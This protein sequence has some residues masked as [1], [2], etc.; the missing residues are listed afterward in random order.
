LDVE[1][2]IVS[3]NKCF[4]TDHR[5]VACL[6]SRNTIGCRGIE[7]LTE[8]KR[9]RETERETEKQRQ[10]ERDSLSAA[11][12]AALPGRTH[13]GRFAGN[14]SSYNKVLP[15]QAPSHSV[16]EL[17]LNERH[18]YSMYGCIHTAM[19]VCVQYQ[20]FILAACI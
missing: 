7:K 6:C 8:S 18:L 13:I 10:R 5:T 12:M 3:K 11:A 19:L 1:T 15:N 4:C 2:M 9:H 20:P 14:I 16:Q 17:H